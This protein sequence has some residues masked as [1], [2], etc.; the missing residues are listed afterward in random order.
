MMKSRFLSTISRFLSTIIR[1]NQILDR[2]PA[3]VW[4]AN[5]VLF[6]LLK[7]KSWI[8][9]TVKGQSESII[10]VVLETD[11]LVHESWFYSFFPR[12]EQ[13]D[14]MLVPWNWHWLEEVYHG[15]C[16]SLSIRAFFKARKSRTLWV[17]IVWALCVLILLNENKTD[18]MSS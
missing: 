1:T 4:S 8:A 9:P 13:S 17:Y 11:F 12:S 14:I 3:V 5:K 16:Q 6:I 10:S 18:T 7:K 2:G 15:I